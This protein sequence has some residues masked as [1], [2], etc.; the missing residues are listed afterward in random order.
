MIKLSEA[1][2]DASLDKVQRGLV[3][4]SWLQDRFEQTDVE[5]DAEFQ[6]KFNGYYRVRNGK[7]WQKSFYTLFQKCKR[8][9][10]D[11]ESVLN[12]L[13][14]STGR[15]EAS[16]SSKLVATCDTSMPVIDQFVLD[17]LGLRKPPQNA[18]D[19]LKKTVELY[20]AVCEQYVA[21]MASSL[22]QTICSRFN[23]RYEWAEISDL[24]KVDLVLWQHRE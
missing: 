10:A 11:F 12:A 17:N 23:Q 14:D 2:I 9:G 4:Y 22:A 6:R 7:E 5:T 16:F 1:A 21:L 8:D 18:A 19:R 13:H 24:K 15:I 3:K 20:E